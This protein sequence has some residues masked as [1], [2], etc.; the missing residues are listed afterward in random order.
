MQ[1]VTDVAR[2]DLPSIGDAILIWLILIE[3]YIVFGIERYA[4]RQP[5]K[6]AETDTAI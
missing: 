3:L 5:D 1:I 4:C 2:Y 6:S